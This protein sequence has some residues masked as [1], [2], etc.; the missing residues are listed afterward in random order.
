M[1]SGCARPDVAVAGLRRGR[2]DA[3]GDDVAGLRRLAAGQAG[4]AEILDVEDDVVGGQRQH[5]RVRIARRA[6]AAAAAIAGPES[7][8]SGSITTVASMPISSACRR[9]KKRKFGPVITIG[10]ANIGSATRSSVC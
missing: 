3:E 9:A 10:G 5:H 4:G 6:T 8:R 1:P 7:R 2:R